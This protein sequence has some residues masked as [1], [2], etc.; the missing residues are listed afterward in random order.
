[1]GKID[2]GIAG[3]FN[4]KAG[5]VFGGNWKGI[6]YM[7]SRSSKR[8]AESTQAQDVQSLKAGANSYFLLDESSVSF[9]SCL[10]VADNLSCL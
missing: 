3:G 2:K 1:M 10:S 5:T 6:G 7:R 8:N 9:I 4:G